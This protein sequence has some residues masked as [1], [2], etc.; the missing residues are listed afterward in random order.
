MSCRNMQS[1]VLLPFSSPP[2]SKLL[3]KTPRKHQLRYAGWFS[4]PRRK[5]FA[6]WPYS[7]QVNKVSQGCLESE[8]HQ[9][10]LENQE[11]QVTEWEEGVMAL[12]CV[13]MCVCMCVPVLSHF[14]PASQQITRT[15]ASLPVCS[16]YVSS[17]LESPSLATGK[18]EIN[19]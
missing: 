9:D 18:R 8:A 1:Q 14:P 16:G 5:T 10:L 19:G 12:L 13:W 17:H 6:C 15:T 7:F 2:A 4:F 3:S 11:S